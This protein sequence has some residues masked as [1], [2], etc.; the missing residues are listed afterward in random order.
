MDPTAHLSDAEVIARTDAVHDLPFVQSDSGEVCFWDIEAT[1]D[2]SADI[3][4]GE[5]FGRLA[6]RVMREF[7]F[8]LLLVTVLRDMTLAGKF[9]GIEAGFLAVVASAARSGS[10]N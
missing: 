9:T 2:H 5:V 8:P 4:K 3:D 10:M 1:G 6:L 7:D